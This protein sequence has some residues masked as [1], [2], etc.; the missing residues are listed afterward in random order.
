MLRRPLRFPGTVVDL[1]DDYE[2]PAP[3]ARTA[4]PFV[5]EAKGMLSLHFD[6]LGVQSLM[7]QESPD[8]LVL[9]YTRTIMEFLKFNPQPSHIGLVGLGG[10]SIP[11]Y[12]RQQLPHAKITIAEISP[13]VIAL[14]DRFQIPP[15][16]EKFLV[17]CEDGIDFVRRQPG[18]FDVLIIDAFDSSGQPPELCSQEFYGDCLNALRPAGVLVV[19][20]CDSGRSMLIPRLQRSFG[21]RVTVVD[22]EDST[23]TIAFA[24]KPTGDSR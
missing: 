24:A 12:C 20:I 17:V 1:F 11:K 2:A 10:G 13:E 9:G 22:G 8:R 14:R 6:L 21:K 4:L 19:N 16:D 3:G 18:E 15:D 7:D 5:C 23:N